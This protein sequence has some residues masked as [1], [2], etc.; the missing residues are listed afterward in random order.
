MEHVDEIET[1]V[2]SPWLLAISTLRG[3]PNFDLLPDDFLNWTNPPLHI[4]HLH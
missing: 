1:F 3:H 2:A 4:L